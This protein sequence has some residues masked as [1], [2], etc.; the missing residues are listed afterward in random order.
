MGHRAAVAEPRHSPSVEEMSINTGNLSGDVS[1]H[2]HG[3]AR[4][5][6]HELQRLELKILASPG[7]QG[8]EILK[9]RGRHKLIPAQAESIKQATAQIFQLG[10]LGGQGILDIFG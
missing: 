6:I 3:T 2:P 7:Q 5:L 9:Q 1:T 10:R 8:L 4:E